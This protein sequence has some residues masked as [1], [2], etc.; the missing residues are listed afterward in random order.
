V[1]KLRTG[2]KIGVCGLVG[3]GHLIK[4][5]EILPEPGLNARFGEVYYDK[6]IELWYSS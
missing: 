3:K 2:H 1:A 6:T 5:G 4:G